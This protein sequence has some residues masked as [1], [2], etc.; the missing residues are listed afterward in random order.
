MAKTVTTSKGKT[1]DIDF[2]WGPLRDSGDVSLQIHDKRP[3]SEV[4]ADFDGVERF[5]KHDPQTEDMVFEG[6]TRLQSI[7][8][9]A[10]G[11][12]DTVLVTVSKPKE[13]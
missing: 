12:D 5:D 3:L 9:R 7:T 4:A 11:A 1:F 13:A 6:Y 2:M 10:N 8:Y